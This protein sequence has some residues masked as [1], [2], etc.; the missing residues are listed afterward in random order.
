MNH[1]STPMLRGIASIS[2][3][4]SPPY[5]SPNHWNHHNSQA[6]C[7]PSPL[8]SPDYVHT[9]NHTLRRSGES[10]DTLLHEELVGKSPR[11]LLPF[12]GPCSTTRSFSGHGPSDYMSSRRVSSSCM[13]ALCLCLCL[14]SSWGGM[15]WW[16]VW[17]YWVVVH[18]HL[19]GGWQGWGL[20][21]DGVKVRG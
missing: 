1:N 17:E 4:I 7:I 12:L 11:R 14:G 20:A 8:N 13:E 16:R 6:D 9:A 2:K 21:G 18:N 19:E 10:K 3:L 5:G 15:R